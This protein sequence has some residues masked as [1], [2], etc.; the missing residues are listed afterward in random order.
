MAA[1]TTNWLGTTSGAFATAGN[2]SNG[3]PVT[4]DTAILGGSAVR[5][6]DASDQS[7]ITLAKLVIEQSYN[8]GVGGGA[9]APLK[10]NATQL[11]CAGG[12]LIFLYGGYAD[13]ALAP[14][15]RLELYIGTTA[16]MVIRCL[17]GKTYLR[18][19]PSGGSISVL[20]AAQP[21][22]YITEVDIDVDITAQS[23]YNDG[24]TIRSEQATFNNY[25]AAEAFLQYDEQTNGTPF[26]AALG[27]VIDWRSTIEVGA[28][29][30][31]SGA[32][33]DMRHGPA[34][35]WN[36]LFVLPDA[37]VDVRGVF[38][39]AAT[40][41]PYALGSGRILQAGTSYAVEHH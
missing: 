1:K 20:L 32:L 12:G 26:V 11:L 30:V 25:V 18:T 15:A 22:G 37:T 9:A 19:G 10:I 21:P 4:G 14:K 2:W 6:L 41:T 7:A 39:L 29:C 17:R 16:N 28:E 33:L 5:K 23:V 40:A 31:I 24:A 38:D 27:G 8:L 3:V 13:C 35:G 34:P 36:G